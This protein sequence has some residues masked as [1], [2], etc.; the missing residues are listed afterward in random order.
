[1]NLCVYVEG[2]DLAHAAGEDVGGQ[3]GPLR[4]LLVVEGDFF[5]GVFGPAAEDAAV[6]DGGLVD[7]EEFAVDGDGLKKQASEETIDVEFVCQVYPLRR[8]VAVEFR[9]HGVDDVGEQVAFGGIV[10]VQQ[11]VG[12]A[13]SVS[14]LFGGDVFVPFLYEKLVRCFDNDNPLGEILL[15]SHG[16]FPPV[17]WQDYFFLQNAVYHEFWRFVKIF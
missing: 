6:Y 8:D 11:R 12:H 14:H 13:A 7:A 1:M 4:G 5:Y 3:L 9:N 16:V 17:T 10:V 2:E 15:A